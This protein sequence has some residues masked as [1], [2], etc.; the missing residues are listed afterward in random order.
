MSKAIE[1][2]TEFIEEQNKYREP[3]KSKGLLDNCSNNIIVFAE[4]M[5]G[6]KP[7]AWQVR[8]LRELQLAAQDPDKLKSKEFGA[9]TS[10]Q[11]GKS[12]SL[13][14]FG[15]WACI[16]NRYPGTLGNNTSMLVISA[17]DV[18]SKKL[19]GE[20]KRMVNM[21]DRFIENTYK[22][23]AGQPQF[24]KSFFTDLLDEDMANNTTTITFKGYDKALHGDF[25]LKDSKIGSIIKSYPPTSMILGET[26]TI[27]AIDEV[28]KTD[29]ISDEFIYDYFYPVGN[30]T[31][32]IKIYTSTPWVTSGFFYRIVD[33]DEIFGESN[34]SVHTFTIEA[35]KLEAPDYYQRVQDNVI[36][37]LNSD[38][39]TDEVQRAYYCRFVKGEQS[40]FNPTKVVEA[41]SRDY[42]MYPGFKGECDMGIDFGGQVTSRTVITIST[43][44]KDNVIKRLYHKTYDV[45]KDKTLLED[46]ELLLKDFNVQRIIPDDCAAGFFL[47]NRMKDKGWNVHPMNFTRD[48]VKKYGGFRSMLNK[49]RIT[50]Y[51]DDEL[52]T[53][54]LAMEFSQGVRNTMIQHAP[55]Y[56][57]DCIDSFVMSGY[58]YI[59]EEN[60]LVTF[61]L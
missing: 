37:K 30:S 46:V 27:I 14:I 24:G 43:L 35:I 4:R 20:M 54:M 48:K 22:D 36:K 8:F 13:A 19:I 9:I 31:N 21:G 25:L 5:L 39:K 23:A 33:P 40:Y 53:E 1:V 16:F 17:S 51:D 6:I 56:T 55:G 29:R 52:K 57:D 11:I 3:D 12:T 26:A 59:D 50:S 2:T 28:G 10:R 41:F 61:E 34:V 38:G 44:D 58:F 7:Y 18:Q 42:Q 49:G 45:G 32:A 47:I 15:L 60:Q